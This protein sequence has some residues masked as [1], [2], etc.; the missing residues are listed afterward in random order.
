M[1]TK[2]PN[3]FVEG[4]HFVRESAW[5]QVGLV[6]LILSQLIALLIASKPTHEVFAYAGSLPLALLVVFFLTSA[7]RPKTQHER[8]VV[9][10]FSV[11]AAVP[12][13]ILGAVVY[14]LL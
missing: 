12:C 4:F 7:V 8:H 2:K 1:G 9:F 5:H 13:W 3:R 11:Y 6:A 10:F 14:R